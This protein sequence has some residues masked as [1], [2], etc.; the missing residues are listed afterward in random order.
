MVIVDSK[1]HIRGTY[2]NISC[3]FSL[4]TRLHLHTDFRDLL[5]L[6]FDE[7]LNLLDVFS[8]IEN[9]QSVFFLISF[10]LGFLCLSIFFVKYFLIL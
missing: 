7:C 3:N 2:Y 9:F 5:R 1:E 4:R 10:R 6:A 8:F